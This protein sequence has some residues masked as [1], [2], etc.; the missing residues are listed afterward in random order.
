MRTHRL[1]QEIKLPA[2]QYNGCL[3]IKL[4]DLLQACHMF[5]NS[6]QSHQISLE[7]L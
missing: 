7:V 3:C 5:F 1:G 2:I 6:A 4:N